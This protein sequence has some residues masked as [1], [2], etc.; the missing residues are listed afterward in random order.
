MATSGRAWLTTRQE[1]YSVSLDAG[2]GCAGRGAE[3]D[4]RRADPSGWGCPLF[5]RDRPVYHSKLSPLLG[6]KWRAGYLRPPDPATD[7]DDDQRPPGDIAAVRARAL[8]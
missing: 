1:L 2:A 4:A 8:R 7:R 3:R 6:A 5:P